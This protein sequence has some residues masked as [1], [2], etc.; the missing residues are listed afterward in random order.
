MRS[1]PRFEALVDTLGFKTY[2]KESA[3]IP[4]YLGGAVSRA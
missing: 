4:D 1:D 3:S 2:W